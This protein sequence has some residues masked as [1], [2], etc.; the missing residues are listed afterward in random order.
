MDER[1]WLESSDPAAMLEFLRNSGKATDRRLRLFGC[2]LVRAVADCVSGE[3]LLEIAESVERRADLGVDFEE[4]SSAWLRARREKERL[5]AARLWPAVWLAWVMQWA[6]SDNLDVL[7]WLESTRIRQRN[8]SIDERFATQAS[9]LRD[10][11]GNPFRLVTAD[12][13]WLTSAVLDVA[14]ATYDERCFDRLPILADA[15]QDAGCDDEVVLTHCRNGRVHARGC[16]VV[17][18]VLGKS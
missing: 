4:L 1:E 10:I 11:F 8:L 6:S 2:G 14:Q 16:W 15:L 18:M 5:V 17:D 3:A 9:I 12:R 13:R 7:N